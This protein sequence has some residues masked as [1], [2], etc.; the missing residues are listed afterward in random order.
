M[1]NQQDA[2]GVTP[3]MM[4][5]KKNNLAMVKLLLAKNVDLSKIDGKKNNVFHYAASSSKDI[6]EVSDY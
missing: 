5:L 2:D 3:I 1:L 4:A 6:I